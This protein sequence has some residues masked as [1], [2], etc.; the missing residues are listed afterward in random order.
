ME[1]WDLF[2]SDDK[3]YEILKNNATDFKPTWVNNVL[4]TYKD[5]TFL[6]DEL[7]I[8]IF[9]AGDEIFNKIINQA[10]GGLFSDYK[11]LYDGKLYYI[12][13]KNTDEYIGL[14]INSNYLSNITFRGFSDILD[15]LEIKEDPDLLNKEHPLYY[16]NQKIKSV[17][18]IPLVAINKSLY[19]INAPS[20][21][22]STS[23]IEYYKNDNASIEECYVLRYD[24]KIKPT[25]LTK[26]ESIKKNLNYFKTIKTESEYINSSFK[27]FVGSQ[28]PPLFPS[29]GYCAIEKKS[30]DFDRW[31]CYIPLLRPIISTTLYSKNN[32][33][34]KIKT[35]ILDFLKKIYPE[36]NPEYI[37]KMYNIELLYDY[38]SEYNTNEYSYQIKLTLK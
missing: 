5:N 12:R 21:S 22:T 7:K 30:R 18:Q 32:E 4:Y 23:E 1:H 34:I 17:K 11:N 6:W 3:Y 29:I 19:I 28:Y 38:V 26:E 25:F 10:N 16:I 35:L 9:I 2:I 31:D 15:D 27:N 14:V 13:F 24:G 20:P 36:L 8:S 37:Y 33:N